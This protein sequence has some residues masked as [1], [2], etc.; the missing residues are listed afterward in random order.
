MKMPQQAARAL[1]VLACIG[2]RPPTLHGQQ[3]TLWFWE[4][5]FFDNYT[6]FIDRIYRG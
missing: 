3:G 2:G 4:K 5:G 1:S 6:I